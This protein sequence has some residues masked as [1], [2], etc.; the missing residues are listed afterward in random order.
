MNASTDD[1]D[2]DGYLFPN[3]RSGPGL[4]GVEVIDND[5][6]GVVVLESGGVTQLIKGS[7]TGDDY[8]VRLTMQPTADVRLAI[9]T[10]GLADVV[11][12]GGVPVVLQAIGEALQ[13]LYSG[14][15]TVDT[16]NRRLVRAGGA[17]W[18]ADGFLEGQR[19]RVINAADPATT[20]TSRSPSSAATTRA[21]TTRSSSPPRARCRLG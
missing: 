5:T 9:V 17:S 13:G 1:V 14:S 15:V 11:S 20:P 21:S 4:L 16:D 2:Y 10:D 3:L 12:I 18:L 19:I 6:P 7:A 8:T